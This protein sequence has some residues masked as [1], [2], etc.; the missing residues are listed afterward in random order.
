[1]ATGER[2]PHAYP[3]GGPLTE[4]ILANSP[5]S[6]LFS[7]ARQMTDPR[8]HEDPLMLLANMTT[9]LRFS[10]I[11]PA[12]QDARVR[13]LADS[14]Y[15]ELGGRG[16]TR[17]HAPEEVRERLPLRSQAELEMFD[18]LYNTLADRAK[19]RKEDRLMVRP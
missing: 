13:E 18:A 19:Q 17:M 12:A 6:R 14:R 9:G 8:K 10:H 7:T 15:K 16:F 1:M 5:Y 11:S 2:T 4:A 3:A